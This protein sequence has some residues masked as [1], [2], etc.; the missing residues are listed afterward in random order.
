[1]TQLTFGEYRQRLADMTTRHRQDVADT[2]A[3]HAQE[4]AALRADQRQERS[5]LD[6]LYNS[7]DRAAM[8]TRRQVAQQAGMDER[9]YII[10]ARSVV[11]ALGKH[12]NP[13]SDG[14]MYL[15]VYETNLDFAQRYADE[16]P[17]WTFDRGAQALYP[18]ALTPLQQGQYN[19]EQ[20]FLLEQSRTVSQEL[21]A[22]NR[23]V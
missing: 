19:H 17:D 2:S 23:R 9:R 22:K 11:N 13:D 15:G 12:F 10:Y 1:M 5:A 8:G 18:L 3:R 6:T 4:L 7:Q 21:A 20:S 14:R 16:N